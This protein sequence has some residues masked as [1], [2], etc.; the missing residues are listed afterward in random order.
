MLFFALFLTT[1][2]LTL[3]APLD[4][5]NDI[6]NSCNGTS[7][8]AKDCADLYKSGGRISNVYS[9]EPRD[10]LGAFDVFCD[11]TTA[12]GGWTVL[13]KRLNGSMDFNRTWDEY[14]HGFGNFFTHEFWLGLDKIHRLTRNETAN[15]LRIELGVTNEE[16]LYAEYGCFGIGNESTTYRLKL[17]HGWGGTV[18]ND[19]FGFHNNF[20]FG[21][22]DRDPAHGKCN[23]ERG[24]GWWYSKNCVVSSN[25]NGLYPSSGTPLGN[26]HWD[27][28]GSTAEASAPENTEMKIRPVDFK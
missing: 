23:K 17:S 28:L 21:T 6:E 3:A 27:D 14:K 16:P 2:L 9:I 13:Q 8:K 7:V 10:G 5:H 19:S 22:W 26:I 11:Q 18:K 20:S 12:G 25:L 4:C 15:R 24:G 1:S